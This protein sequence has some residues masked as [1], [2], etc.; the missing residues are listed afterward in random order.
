MPSLLKP[1]S[2]KTPGS[3]QQQM[4]AAAS[5]KELVNTSVKSTQQFAY[6]AAI[7]AGPRPP[8]N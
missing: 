4:D 3:V 2:E 8:Q 6:D 5:A 7:N 1:V